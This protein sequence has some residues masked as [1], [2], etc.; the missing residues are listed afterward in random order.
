MKF[1]SRSMHSRGRNKRITCT[2]TGEPWLAE[3][4][5]I[6]VDAGHVSINH[7]LVQL[8][9]CVKLYLTKLVNVSLCDIVIVMADT[10]V[11]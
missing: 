4:F 1:I 8:H 11:G 6:S 3:R 2:I 5:P 7:R 10:K 9:Q